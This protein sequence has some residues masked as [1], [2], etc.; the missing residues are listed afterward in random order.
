[1]FFLT[2]LTGEDQTIIKRRKKKDV[3][4]LIINPKKK[5]KSEKHAIIKYIKNK[6]KFL[7]Q[8]LCYH[9]GTTVLI[10]SEEIEIKDG[11]EIITY[12]KTK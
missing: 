11:K 5:T 9:C 1:M 8:D 10:Q 12:I 6:G 4:D 2:E 7:F 3:V